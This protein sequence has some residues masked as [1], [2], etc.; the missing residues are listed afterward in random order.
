MT[1]CDI[2]SLHYFVDPLQLHESYAKTYLM[3]NTY[4]FIYRL[5]LVFGGGLG[6]AKVKRDVVNFSMFQ[7][8]KQEQHP[9][10]EHGHTLQW[11]GIPF[12]HLYLLQISQCRLHILA[13]HTNIH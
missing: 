9:A 5:K 4:S 8:N 1:Y 13:D 3:S 10:F 12:L 11:V 6:V 7:F 2:S